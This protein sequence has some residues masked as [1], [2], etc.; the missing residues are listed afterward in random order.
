MSFPPR[1]FPLFPSPPPPPESTLFKIPV[2][3]SEESATVTVHVDSVYFISLLDGTI[4]IYQRNFVTLHPNTP[5]LFLFTNG[6]CF[7][8]KRSSSDVLLQ[9]PKN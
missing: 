6:T 1:F 2:F 4:W 8:R 3:A 5:A 7:D 9:S